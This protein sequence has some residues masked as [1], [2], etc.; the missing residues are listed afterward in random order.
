MDNILNEALVEDIK[1]AN[2]GSVATYIPELAKGD[3]NDVG[4]AMMD[5]EGNILSRG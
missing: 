4:F 5:L 1:V 3:P 2:G